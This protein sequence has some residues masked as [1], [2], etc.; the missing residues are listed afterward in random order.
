MD[1]STVGTNNEGTVIGGG[2][3]ASMPSNA[4][5]GPGGS[6]RL[7]FCRRLEWYVSQVGSTGFGRDI[8]KTLLLVSITSQPIFV[9]S[10]KNFILTARS[11]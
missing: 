5:Q 6:A 1:T 10:G 2:S 8:R 3:I 11:R 9:N 4:A 7:E